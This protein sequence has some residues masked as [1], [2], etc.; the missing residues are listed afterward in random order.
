[1][2]RGW[3]RDHLISWDLACKPKEYRGL[4]L[5]KVSSRNHDLL[6]KRLG[7]FPGERFDFWPQVILSIY[8]TY[9]NE[10]NTNILVRWSHRCPWKTLA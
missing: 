5:G 8:K 4:G 3:I 7:R 6:G 9:P 10:W 2:V 1:M